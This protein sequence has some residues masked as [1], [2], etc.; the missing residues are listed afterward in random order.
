VNVK[1]T[2]KL[3]FGACASPRHFL[4]HTFLS[5]MVQVLVPLNVSFSGW[6]FPASIAIPVN[7]RWGLTEGAG[8]SVP[9]HLGSHVGNDSGNGSGVGSVDRGIPNLHSK[10]KRVMADNA[11]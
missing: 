4:R 9:N 11:T 3:I 6:I 10:L 1:T 7:E 8:K 2:G 5:V